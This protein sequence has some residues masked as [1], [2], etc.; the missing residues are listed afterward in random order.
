MRPRTIFVCFIGGPFDG[1]EY[2]WRGDVESLVDIRQHLYRLD[3]E[4][5]ALDGK[6]LVATYVYVPEG[7][8]DASPSH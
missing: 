2:R 6:R 7:V 4:R 3:R 8:A 1:L 5:S